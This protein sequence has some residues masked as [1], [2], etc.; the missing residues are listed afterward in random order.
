MEV[1]NYVFCCPPPGKPGP[2]GTRIERA[3]QKFSDCGY[4]A[5][6]ILRDDQKIGK[7]FTD[8]QREERQVEVIISNHKKSRHKIDSTLKEHVFFA[9]SLT[10]QLRGM[11]STIDREFAFRLL[12]DMDNQEMPAEK[13][14]IAKEALKSYCSQNGYNDFLKF[15][16][17]SYSLAMI[18]IHENLLTALGFQ[19]DEL[20]C[21]LPICWKDLTIFQKRC[22]LG[23]WATKK[24]ALAYGCQQSSWNPGQPIESLVNTLKDH[25]PH[26]VTGKLGQA[27]YKKN[28]TLSKNKIEGRHLYFWPPNSEKEDHE[29]GHTV[30]IIGA[31]KIYT[32]TGSQEL[33]YFLDPEDGSK[34]NDV[35]TQKVYATSY[36]NLCNSLHDLDTRPFNWTADG[37][38]IHNDEENNYAFYLP[39]KK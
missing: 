36:K 30:V 26:M 4:R 2:Q 19:T 10:Q 22:Y 13:N 17:D 28:P 34:P 37:R 35:G 29:V 11:C 15:T 7:N 27:Y 6:Q 5:L 33:V 38:V 14:A 18:K 12:G 24:S 8:A 3:S 20:N 9:E 23:A 1:S 31:K 21:N 16:K 39:K 25:G 32:E